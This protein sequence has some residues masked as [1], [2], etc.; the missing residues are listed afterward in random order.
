MNKFSGFFLVFEL[1]FRIFC[2]SRDDI[3]KEYDS[4]MVYSYLIYFALKFVK[5]I[6]HS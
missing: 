4:K 1:L 3:V 6:Y 5:L 2:F